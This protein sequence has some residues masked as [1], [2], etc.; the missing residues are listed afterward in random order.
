MRR[1]EGRDLG[2][3]GREL[4]LQRVH[5]GLCDLRDGVVNPHPAAQRGV[6]LL[7]VAVQHVHAGDP[8]G[9]ELPLATDHRNHRLQQSLL[10]DLREA[11]HDTLTKII[12]TNTNIIV[13]N[14]PSEVLGLYI[15]LKPPV[16]IAL[17][18]HQRLSL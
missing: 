13:K 3:G 8:L 2:F 4:E 16:T 18:V 6:V 7:Q 5:L 9:H 11:V 1:G 15:S 17:N 10:R 12:P 14:I